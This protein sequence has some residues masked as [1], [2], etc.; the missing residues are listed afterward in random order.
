LDSVRTA[1]SKL[2]LLVVAGWAM[3]LAG[4]EPAAAPA[5]SCVLLEKEGAVEV[6]R[7]G[8]T[9]F[10]EAQ[11][12]DRFQAG[13]LVKTGLRSRAVLRWSETSMVRLDQATTTE[14]QDPTKPGANP[15]LNLRSGRSYFFNR[16]KPTELRFRT[17]VASGAILGT[18]FELAV[19]DDG[20]TVLSLL[21]GEVELSNAQGAAKLKSGEQGTVEPGKAPTKTALIDAINV[22]Q[23]VLYYPAVVDPEELGLSEQ[24]KETFKDS[25]KGYREIVLLTARNSETEGRTLGSDAEELIKTPS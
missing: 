10:V 3:P 2:L 11:V 9:A 4:A 19:A 20:R 8:A 25:L 1:G 21:D 12:N 23:W 13:D 22:I 15:E 7:K 6:Q 24:E 18:E 16:D 14:L 5:A 17:P